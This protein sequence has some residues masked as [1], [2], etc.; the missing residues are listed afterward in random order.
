MER[1]KACEKEMK[2][3]AFSKEGLSQAAKLDPSEK[4]RMDMSNWVSSQVDILSQLVE[5][6]EAE[7]E[8]LQSRKKKTQDDRVEELER[9][10]ERRNFH[11]GRL[12]IMMR[13][14][15]NGQLA[16]EKVADIKEDIAYF[17]ESHQVCLVQSHRSCVWP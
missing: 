14:L 16:P 5:T 10:N 6:S 1:F 4:L 11:I 8:S 13:L 15:E 7:I 9:L 12:E 2:T 3:K 17:V